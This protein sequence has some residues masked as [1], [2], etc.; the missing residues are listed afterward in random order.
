MTRFLT[1][2]I[3]MSFSP[4]LLWAWNG[5]TVGTGPDPSASYQFI[6]ELDRFYKRRAPELDTALVP[7]PVGDFARTLSE[8][9]AG[10]LD[11][12]VLPLGMAATNGKTR[13]LAY[14]WEVVLV[15]FA[16]EAGSDE[17]RPDD[18]LWGLSNG[19]ILPSL[20]WPNVHLAGTGEFEERFTGGEPGIF[21]AEIVGHPRILRDLLKQEIF[22]RDL[23]PALMQ[24]LKNKKPWLSLVDLTYKSRHKTLGYPM[25]LVARTDLGLEPLGKLYRILIDLPSDIWPDPYILGQLK[26]SKTTSLPPSILHPAIQWQPNETP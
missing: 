18:P 4:G 16:P 26:I 5:L 17:V 11:L 2:L 3:F 25:V 23:S 24:Q 9:Q 20:Q 21:L 14:L 13:V 7:T 10:R 15:P 12:A 19:A 6:Q 8:L 22:P 1:L